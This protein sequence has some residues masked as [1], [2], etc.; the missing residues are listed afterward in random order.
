[1][2]VPKDVWVSIISELAREQ[3]WANFKNEVARFNGR[4]DYES[5]L[6]RVWHVMHN[7]QSREEKG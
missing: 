5:S 3:E 6:Q 7:L 1:M 4:D 2:I